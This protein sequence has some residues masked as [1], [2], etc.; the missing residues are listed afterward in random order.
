MVVVGAAGGAVSGP[1]GVVVVSEVGGELP[2]SEGEDWG[3][4]G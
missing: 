2:V 4:A 3:P 1:A